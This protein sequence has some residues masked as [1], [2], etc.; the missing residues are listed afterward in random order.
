[1]DEV[2]ALAATVTAFR[3]RG[4]CVGV[5]RLVVVVVWLAIML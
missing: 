5:A 1:V 2:R 3:R 4:G